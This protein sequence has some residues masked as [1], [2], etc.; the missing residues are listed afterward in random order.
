VRKKNNQVRQ[1]QIKIF[2]IFSVQIAIN[3]ELKKSRTY[4]ASF[5]TASLS[6]CRKAEKVQEIRCF[7]LDG[8]LC[9]VVRDYR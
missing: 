4:A 5:G 3:R 6:G 9:T 1:K 7:I 8:T 2:P